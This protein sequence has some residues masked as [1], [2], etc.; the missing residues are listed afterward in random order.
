MVLPYINMNPH[1]CTHVPHPEPPSHLPPHTIPLGH[2]SA[3][4]PSI[5]YHASSLDWRFVSH[6][7]LYMFQCHSPKSSHP[8]PLPQSPKDCSTLL[9][10]YKKKPAIPVLINWSFKILS[11]TWIFF[12]FF[13]L[14]S[15]LLL[16]LMSKFYDL[17]F[18]RHHKNINFGGRVIIKHYPFHL[19]SK[20][21]YQIP[22]PDPLLRN[23]PY[24]HTYGILLFLIY[25][26]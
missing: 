24:P 23:T 13:F 25:L 2:P 6:M 12:I 8:R 21:P 14:Y 16:Y 18:S 17:V 1:G 4:A 5:L 11:S 22:S 7:L 26:L 10:K 20:R 9:L 19:F 3:S 15:F